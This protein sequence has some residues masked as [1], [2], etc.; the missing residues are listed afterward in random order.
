MEDEERRLHMAIIAG[1]VKAVEY[2]EKKPR[3]TREEIIQ[4]ITNMSKEILENIDD[5]L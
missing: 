3:A 5:P 2:K 4:H 1:A